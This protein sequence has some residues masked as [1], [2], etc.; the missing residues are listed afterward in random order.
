MNLDFILFA[1]PKIKYQF[2][3]LWGEVVFIP[4]YVPK[5]E[6]TVPKNQFLSEFVNCYKAKKN[7]EV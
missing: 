6:K 1:G 5:G 3:D 4:S 2:I 7:E